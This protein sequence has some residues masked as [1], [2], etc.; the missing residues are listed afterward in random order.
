MSKKLSDKDKKVWE[1]FVNSKEKIEDK[2][3]KYEKKKSLYIKKTIDLNGYTLKDANVKIEKFILLCFEKGVTKIN[4]ITGKGSRSNNLNDPYQSKD[5]SIL[6]Y[7]IP[8][9]IEENK[10]LMNKI[11]KIDFNAVESSLKGSF[12]VILKKKSG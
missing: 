11:L 12:D 3:L 6:K 2:D 10:N 9:F 8:N 4:I 1:E 5:L 7:S